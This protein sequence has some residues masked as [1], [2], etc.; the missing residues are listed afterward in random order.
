MSEIDALIATYGLLAVFLGII[1]EGETVV[2][3]AG[4]L[5]HRGDIG[6]IPLCIVAFLGTL[7]ADN[8]FFYIGVLAG[9]PFLKRL[10]FLDTRVQNVKKTFSKH[11]LVVLLSF[12]FMY[13]F[14]IATPCVIGMSRYNKLYFLFM[15]SISAFLWSISYAC[16]GYLFG[17]AIDGLIKDA[18]RYELWIALGMGA[19]GSGVAIWQMRRLVRRRKIKRQQSKIEEIPGI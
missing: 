2:L 19:I 6:I 13:G 11:P 3:I 7:T 17:H 15:D 8:L 12:R 1:I 18:H 16:A 9:K 14:R 10:P 4:L 5:A